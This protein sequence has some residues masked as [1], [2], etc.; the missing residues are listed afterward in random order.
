MKS[1]YFLSADVF[2][3]D[4]GTLSVIEENKTIPFVMKRCFF[5]YDLK[6]GDV[7]GKHAV[8]NEQCIFLLSGKCSL[9]VHNGK[10]EERFILSKPME[11]I[12]I[13]AMQ[14]REVTAM[15]PGTSIAVFSDKYYN[16][17]DYIRDFDAFLHYQ[18]SLPQN[19]EFLKK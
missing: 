15:V 2:S 8:N 7:R 17:D 6:S 10:K 18:S 13:P 11:G 16:A 4:N 5:I 3:Q 12:F 9:S 19:P 14:W 1:P